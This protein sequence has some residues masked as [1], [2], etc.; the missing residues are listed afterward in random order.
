[1]REEVYA[2]VVKL[3]KANK[4]NSLETPKQFE[5]L[6]E[7]FSVDND[8]LTPTFKLKRNIARK[9]FAETITKLYALPPLVAKKPEKKE[10]S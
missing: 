7:P 6:K 10:E 5:L 9:F 4:L 3:C 8:L 1:M 2:D